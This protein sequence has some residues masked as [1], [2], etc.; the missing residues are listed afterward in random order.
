VR[1]PSVLDASDLPLA[2]RCAI[3]LDGDGFVLGDGII[4]ADEPDGPAQRAASVAADARRYRLVLGGWT[5]AWVHGGTDRLRRPLDLQTDSDGGV[6]TKLLRIRQVA[7]SHRDVTVLAGVGV[8][9]PLRT[10]V[11]LARLEPA[12]SDESRHAIEH[13]I[14]G[15]GLSWPRAV[16]AV[17]AM[18]TTP[19]KQRALARF[20]ALRDGVPPGRAGAPASAAQVDVPHGERIPARAP[21]PGAVGSTGNGPSQ[22][23]DTR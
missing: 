17:A 2:E 6:R 23:A 5:A 22:P 1:L 9:T 11:D 8:T 7:F 10:A 13:L 16:A 14:A 20:R 12:L 3:R 4:A 19:G 18:P 21:A 15:S